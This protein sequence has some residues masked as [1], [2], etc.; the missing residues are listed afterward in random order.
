MTLEHEPPL[1]RLQILQLT[2]NKSQKAHLNSIN[3]PLG[4]NWDL[5]LI[6]E[7]YI[8]PLG[9][10]RTPNGFKLISPQDHFLNNSDQTRSVIWVNSKLSLNSWKVMNIAGT[11]DITVLQIKM[12]DG[13]LSIF[14]I[15]NDCTHSLMLA[16]LKQFIHLEQHQNLTSA[17]DTI[18]WGGNFNWHHPLWDDDGDERLFT[19]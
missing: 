2:L 7:P 18:L 1:N 19:S 3:R 14:N 4:N 13:Q 9:H 12:P 16:K 17:R 15:Y 5:M 10:I 11:N 6:Q 8:T